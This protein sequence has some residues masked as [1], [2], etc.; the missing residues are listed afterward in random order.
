MICGAFVPQAGAADR[1]AWNIEL[2]YR[3]SSI[4]LGYRFLSQTHKEMNGASIRVTGLWNL[5]PQW[6]AGCGAGFS[7]MDPGDDKSMPLFLCGR[8]RPFERNLNWF[9]QAN[10]GARLFNSYS[11]GGLMTGLELGFQKMFRPHFGLRFSIG[12]ELNQFAHAAWHYIDGS[13]EDENGWSWP[14]IKLGGYAT[15]WRNSLELS[16]GFVF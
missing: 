8:W 7:E 2:D 1:P 9:A 6:S 14:D 15:G 4:G 12:Y 13:T 11:D 5:K 16:F 10:L 3:N